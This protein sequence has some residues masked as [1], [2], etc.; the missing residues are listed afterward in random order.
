MFTAATDARAAK[1]EPDAASEENEYAGARILV[2]E[3]N[4]IN[5]QIIERILLR[6]GVTVESASN[7]R[8]A[9][10]KTLSPGAHFDAVLMDVQMP[11]MDGMEATRL[12]RRK[13]DA[14]QLPIIAMT[15][16][17]MEDDRRLCLEAGMNDHLPKPIDPAAVGHMLR[18]WLV[19]RTSRVL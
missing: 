8:E 5:L 10:N 6:Y 1:R 11:E 16:H 14:A 13:L 19:P 7:G 9:V 18:R 12:I 2:A 15:A 17:A 4:Q 3:D